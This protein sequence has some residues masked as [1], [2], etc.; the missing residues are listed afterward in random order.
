MKSA[1]LVL[2]SIN[3]K[4]MIPESAYE[5]KIGFADG[6]FTPVKFL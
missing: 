1:I 6:Y 2:C 5:M 3:H 4:W